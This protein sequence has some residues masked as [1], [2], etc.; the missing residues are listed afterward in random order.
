M[1]YKRMDGS[2][3]LYDTIADAIDDFCSEHNRCAGCPL[4]DMELVSINEDCY[5]WAERNPEKAAELMGLVAISDRDE[6]G[7]NTVD[8]KPPL[9][10]APYW[11]VA[12]A[13]IDELAQAIQRY[14]H[15]RDG[16]K[17]IRGW[18][19]E[20]VEQCDLLHY[21]SIEYEEDEV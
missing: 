19:A 18:A 6:A 7:A 12:Q 20:I 1:G 4:E 17:E 2:G 13:R 21:M 5:D 16:Y 14:S 15:E 10:V 3:I 8:V 9:G 11:A